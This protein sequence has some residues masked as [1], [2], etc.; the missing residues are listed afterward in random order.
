ML[1]YEDVLPVWVTVEDLKI[2]LRL[3]FF[4]SVHTGRTVKTIAQRRG[5]HLSFR[6]YRLLLYVFSFSLHS[7]YPYF[8]LCLAGPAKQ[9][10]CQY[11]HLKMRS[12]LPG[13]L[14]CSHLCDHS[15]QWQSPPCLPCVHSLEENRLT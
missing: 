2:I 8:S 7:V 5:G 15:S 12:Y 3:Y 13:F 4:A 11:C 1:P 10:F 6:K 14:G 9:A